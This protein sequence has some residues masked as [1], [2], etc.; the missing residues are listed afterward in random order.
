MK[1]AIVFIAI[2]VV[3]VASSPPGTRRPL[4]NFQRRQQLQQQHQFQGQ[5][6]R[7]FQQK[8]NQ[9]RLEQQQQQEQVQQ[10]QQLPL[11]NLRDIDDPSQAQILR[12]ENDNIGVGPY[13][14]A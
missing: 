13:N 1:F 14:Y 2:F 4:R 3:S 8:Q 11:D 6:Q 7:Q 10:Q 9:L 12:F 5:Y